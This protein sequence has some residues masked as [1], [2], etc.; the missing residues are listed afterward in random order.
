MGDF[1]LGMDYCIHSVYE[2]IVIYFLY[3]K[4]IAIKYL[5]VVFILSINLL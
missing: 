1:W 2:S 5:N 4:R 3:I